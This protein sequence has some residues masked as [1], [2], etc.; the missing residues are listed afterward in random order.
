MSARPLR[1]AILTHSVNPRGGVVH[2]LELSSA[3]ADLGHE[4]VVHAP[5]GPGQD[6]FRTAPF[7]T[8][9]VPA[10]QHGAGTAA[11]VEARIADYLAHFS[12][13]ANRRFDV[14]HAQDSISANA[15]AAL[16]SRGLIPGF[17]RTV[18]HLD[19]FA[20]PRLTSWQ[21][22]GVEA[23]SRLFVVSR[24]WQAH[25]N[26][27]Y[28]RHSTLVGNGVDLHRFTPVP[29]GREAQLAARLGLGAGPVFLSVGGVE[30]RKNTLGIL[31]GFIGLRHAVPDAQLVIAGGASLLDHQGYRRR[32]ERTLADARLPAGAVRVT[33]PLPDI[34]M[35]AL[36]R[37][38]D[39]LVF[40]SLKEGFGLCVLE[41]M[42]S[43][44]P[45]VASCIAPFTEY[46]DPADALWCD[47]LDPRTIAD[48][49]ALS[50]RP[51]MRRRLVE[52]GHGVAARQS[53]RRAAEAHLAAYAEFEEPSYA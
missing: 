18:H 1:I 4:P 32:F 29:D 53:W 11:M 3:L 6:F 12:H 21:R 35:P 23:A 36:Y 31:A 22:H 49:M 20:D 38:A 25:L 37:L 50:L 51:D 42:A 30:D 46:L 45:V 13:Q 33:G 5:A 48:A 10:S 39:T 41:A 16:R 19:R 28:G 44:V 43:G 2:A 7:R 47:P 26:E 14:F 15:L 9:R 27:V 24:L 34:D 8:V 40:P 17:V 52:R